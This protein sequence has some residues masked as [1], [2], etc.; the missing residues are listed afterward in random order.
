VLRLNIVSLPM[1]SPK[2]RGSANSFKNSTIPYSLAGSSTAT[3]LAQSTSPAT[4]F[5]TNAPNMLKLTCT[6]SAKE[7]LLGLSEFFTFQPLPNL[8]MS[9]PKASLQLCL[10]LFA[11]VSTSFPSTF[12]L[13]GGGRLIYCSTVIS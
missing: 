12:R 11:P 9:S 6:S 5:S 13:Q 1:V 7:L 4:P 3:M 10:L 2:Y 8:P